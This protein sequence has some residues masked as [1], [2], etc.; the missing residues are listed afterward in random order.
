MRSRNTG[1]VHSNANHST[2]RSLVQLNL[3]VVLFGVTSLFAKFV[4]LP[5]PDVILGRSAVAAAALLLYSLVTSGSLRVIHRRDLPLILGLGAVLALHWVTYFQ[6]IRVSTVA[7]GTISLHTY[8]IMT[9]LLEPIVDRKAIRAPDLILAAMV[10][11]GIVIL[12][13][14]F[15]LSS[16]VSQGVL[17]GALSALLFTIRN[18]V[19]RRLVQRYSGSMLMFYQTLVSAL[20]LLPWVG[21]S[22]GLSA[23]ISQWPLLLVLGTVFTALTQSLYAGSLRRLSAKTVSI[24]ASLL[25]LYSTV[26]ALVFLGEVPAIRTIVGGIIVVGAVM[27]E[28]AR[29]SGDPPPEPAG[30]T[31]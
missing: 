11:V 28:T 15:S 2:T 17:L 24:L 10:L 21:F 5:I 16:D 30:K 1:P 22:H 7:V 8:P 9:V 20:V 14:D 27:I 6:G 26:F 23:T 12:V 29:A 18:L 31:D 19:V 4:P 3:A 25:P 13:P